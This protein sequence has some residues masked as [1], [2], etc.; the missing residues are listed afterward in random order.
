MFKLI[1]SM[2]PMCYVCFHSLLRL[3]CSLHVLE[4]V[5]N[6]FLMTLGML[7]LTWLAVNSASYVHTLKVIL[8]FLACADAVHVYRFL[9]AMIYLFSKGMWLHN[10][11]T[12]GFNKVL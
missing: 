8:F 4:K 11:N 5:I 10:V 1:T 6:T 9:M 2:Y 12:I 7:R 3:Y